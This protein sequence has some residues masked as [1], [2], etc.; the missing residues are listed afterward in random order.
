MAEKGFPILPSTKRLHVLK[1][2]FKRPTIAVAMKYQA[3]GIGFYSSGQPNFEPI[4][5]VRFDGKTRACFQVK[6]FGIGLLPGQQLFIRKHLFALLQNPLQ[7][8]EPHCVKFAL[9]VVR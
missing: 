2:R 5:P 9:N 8:W 3:K 1:R 4:A 6:Y 7:G